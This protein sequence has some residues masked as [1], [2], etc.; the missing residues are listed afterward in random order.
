MV[1]S[2]ATGLIR[3]FWYIARIYIACRALIHKP[4][5]KSISVEFVLFLLLSLQAPV[6]QRYNVH[7]P[8][9]LFNPHLQEILTLSRGT[10]SIQ[11][12]HTQDLLPAETSPAVWS[13]VPFLIFVHRYCGIAVSSCDCL[14]SSTVASASPCG[15]PCSLLR[16][17]HTHP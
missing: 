1:T 6:D 14:I 7:A 10:L 4:F 12:W 16:I 15:L 17:F 8:A 5:C 2:V 9:L 11:V 13:I 3:L